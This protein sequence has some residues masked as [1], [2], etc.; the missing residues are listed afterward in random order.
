MAYI[1][2]SSQWMTL[3][4]LLQLPLALLMYTHRTHSAGVCTISPHPSME[5]LVA[6]GSYDERVRL[7]DMRNLQRP[8]VT[9]EVR[10]LAEMCGFS[11]DAYQ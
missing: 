3:H 2:Y 8:V 9:A 11:A 10:G 7:W 6:T 1:N 4:S 5:H